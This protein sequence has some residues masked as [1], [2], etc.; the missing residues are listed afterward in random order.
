MKKL[1]LG[2]V[3]LSITDG[4][5]TTVVDDKS[6]TCFLL[7]CKN[8]KNGCIM[9]NE[10]DRKIS[11][12]TMIQLRN[13]TK[14]EMDDVLLTTVGTIGQSSIVKDNFPNYE[15]Q[16]SVAILKPNKDI[17]NH[18]YLHYFL[19]SPLGQNLIRARIKGAVQSC[20]FLS[21]IKELKICVPNLFKQQHIVNILGT[22]DDKIENNEKIYRKIEQELQLVYSKYL[23]KNN[24]DK[25]DY[26]YI[27]LTDISE[28]VGGYSYKGNELIKSK[29][30]MITIKNFDRNG[31]FKL[32]GFKDLSE[33]NSAKSAQYVD[34]YDIVVAH[35][36]LTQNA[37][38]IGN[39]EIILNKKHYEKLIASMDLVIVR[40]KEINNNLLYLLLHNQDF[41]KHALG[42]CAGTTVLHLNKK[43]LQEYRVYIPKEKKLL[44]RIY[45]TISLLISK[46]SQ[47][48]IKNQ[49]LTELKQLYLKKFFD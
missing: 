29:Y 42:Y 11:V 2:D 35:T 3:C 8:I 32:D 30:G 48:I 21:D 31:G 34:L 24:I 33:N 12:S 46:Q 25:N 41:K 28:F 37:E 45:N 20:L 49:K 47:L 10:N 26:N 16:R 13:R 40:P 43:A 19:I 38:I 44:E 18:K 36:D 1:K 5:H 6:G 39:A 4:T 14:M 9:I 22:I 27:P 7:S 15:F 17:I 23:S